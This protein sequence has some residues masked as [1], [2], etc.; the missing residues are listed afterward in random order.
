[1]RMK[2][3]GVWARSRLVLVAHLG[4]GPFANSC[5]EHLLIQN[6]VAHGYAAPDLGA[7][8]DLD[9][10]YCLRLR[11]QGYFKALRSIPE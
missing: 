11:T 4:T 9:D 5:Y 3:I 6:A 10:A 1:M 8:G 2:P 7:G